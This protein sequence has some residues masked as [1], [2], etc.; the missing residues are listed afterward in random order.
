LGLGLISWFSGG[1]I[2][3][4]KECKQ[5]F[6]GLFLHV[7]RVKFGISLYIQAVATNITL[8]SCTAKIILRTAFFIPPPIL[9]GG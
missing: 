9:G 4:K 3:D 1:K 6:E 7:F 5:T 8:F 2:K